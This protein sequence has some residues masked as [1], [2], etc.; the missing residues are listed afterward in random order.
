MA[1]NFFKSYGN[2]NDEIG[3]SV[4]EMQDS[5]FLIF[6]SSSSF[7]DGTSNFYLMKID[8]L[9]NFNWSKTYGGNNVEQGYD[10]CYKP[11]RNYLLTGYTNSFGNGYEVYAIE[12]DSLGNELWS[13]TYGGSDWDFAYSNIAFPNGDV[14]ITGNTYSFGNGDSDGFLM[15]LDNNGDSLWW[16]NYGTATENVLRQSIFTSHSE[17]V[18]IGSTVTLNGDK[19][20]YLVKCNLSG[21]TIWTKTY[22]STVDDEGYSLLQSIN[23]NYIL[24]GYTEG[25]TAIGKDGYYFEVDT[26]GT[27]LWSQV[28]P[29]PGSGEEIF[30]AICMKPN[31]H[32]FYAAW[33][34]TTFGN[35]EYDFVINSLYTN[36]GWNSASNTYGTLMT[37]KG[38]DIIF[39]SHKRVLAVGY[40]DYPFDNQNVMV[41]MSDTLLPTQQSS[42]LVDY[43]DVTSVIDFSSNEAIK[44]YP[45]PTTSFINIEAT[46]NIKS[47]FIRDLTG[48]VLS[49]HFGNINHLNVEFLEASYYLI[50][51]ELENGNTFVSKL[52]ITKQ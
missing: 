16:K 31:E 38:Y 35:G 22:G 36:G 52:A 18:S 30:N 44:L 20:I 45:N 49:K 25:F 46:E 34:T 5:S 7:V 11:N 3:R 24:A 47:V 28:N 1:Q 48:K 23:G 9:G 12:V 8:S 6:G 14:L 27:V 4:I 29:G 26:S 41:I 10:I 42:T 32:R 39:T 51:I 40:T 43:M 33:E 50:E 17:I 15:M 2:L 21:D 13:N 37:E 19:D